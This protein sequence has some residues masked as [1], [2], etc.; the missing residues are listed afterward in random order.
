MSPSFPGG[1][2][3]EKPPYIR[4]IKRTEMEKNVNKMRNRFWIGRNGKEWSLAVW[5]EDGEERRKTFLTKFMLRFCVIN[6]TAK[7]YREL[8]DPV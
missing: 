7:G 3:R 1:S 5:D 2:R 6:L 4:I 8:K